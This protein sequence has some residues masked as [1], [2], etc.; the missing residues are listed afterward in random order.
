MVFMGLQ[1]IVAVVAGATCQ[2]ASL[3][4]VLL[5]ETELQHHLATLGVLIPGYLGESQSVSGLAISPGI[6]VRHLQAKASMASVKMVSLRNHER[7]VC[8]TEKQEWPGI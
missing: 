5:E 3:L 6:V 4:P 7:H 2:I 8:S 1:T